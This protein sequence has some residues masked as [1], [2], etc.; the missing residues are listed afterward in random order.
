MKMNEKLC[1]KCKKILNHLRETNMDTGKEITIV[2][3][4][5]DKE[6]GHLEWEIEDE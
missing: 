5:C 1:P 2:T 4:Y 3:S 6:C